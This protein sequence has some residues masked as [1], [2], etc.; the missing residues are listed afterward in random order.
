MSEEFSSDN[1]SNFYVVESILDKVSLPLCR[2]TSERMAGIRPTI[3]SDGKDMCSKLGNPSKTCQKSKRWC[4]S[5]NSHSKRSRVV[6]FKKRDKT[7]K[8]LFTNKWGP[9]TSEVGPLKVSKMV[10]IHFKRR[11]PKSQIWE[12]KIRG[13]MKSIMFDSK[14]KDWRKGKQKRRACF[15]S[16]K[17]R[18]I[19]LLLLGNLT[20][21]SQ[22]TKLAN[23]AK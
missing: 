4:D 14:I 13:K 6:S 3:W 21:K 19:C 1:A 2:N 5:L 10:R 17:G 23:T 15:H 20:L 18:K 8:A 11:L 22:R 9:P 7:L 12:G 16:N